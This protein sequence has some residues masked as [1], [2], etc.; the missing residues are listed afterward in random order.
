VAVGDG[1][2]RP[3]TPL[4]GC[5]PPHASRWR[6][7]VQQRSPADAN[8]TSTAARRAS[9]SACAPPRLRPQPE[10]Q[11]SVR[12]KVRGLGTRPSPR[13]S[14]QSDLRVARIGTAVACRVRPRRSY[15]KNARNTAIRAPTDYGEALRIDSRPRADCGRRAAGGTSRRGVGVSSWS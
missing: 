15:L 2:E 14:R 11:V 10:D 6:A 13:A 1:G 8:A 4:P 7:A 12:V 9:A 3:T 5:S